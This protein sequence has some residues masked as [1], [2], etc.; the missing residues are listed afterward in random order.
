LAIESRFDALAAQVA[1]IPGVHGLWLLD[2]AGEVVA[3]RANTP[4]VRYAIDGLVNVVRAARDVGVTGAPV[5]FVAQTDGLQI[6]VR[7]LDLHALV[8]VCALP[9]NLALVRV[10][11]TGFNLR[12]NYP[13]LPP[14][15]LADLPELT[16]TPWPSSGF[17]MRPSMP[18]RPAP[19]PPPTVAAAEEDR[20]VRSLVDLIGP[21][22]SVLIRRERERLGI[23]PTIDREQFRALAEACAGHIDNAADQKRFL[24][25]TLGAR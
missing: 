25:R 9:T 5:W 16:P 19:P 10:G 15:M 23:G 2:A 17:D 1:S 12:T 13:S 8:A 4:D 18:S 21:Y 6:L 3:R 22:A 11:I 20:L 7:W 14:M 24:T